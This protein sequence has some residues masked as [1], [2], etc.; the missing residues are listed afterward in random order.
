MEQGL[1]LLLQLVLEF[2]PV[3]VSLIQKRTE[4][5]LATTNYQFPKAIKEFAQSVNI[6]TNINNYLSGGFEQEKLLQKQLA[7]YHRE[8]QLQIVNQKRDTAL[9]LPEVHKILD[10]WP[11]RLYPSQILDS[12]SSDRTPLKIFLAPPQVHFDQFACRTEGASEIELILAEGIREFINKYYSLQ[13][14]SRPTELLAGA[15][16]S[17]RF[18]SE[19]S[20]KALFG[21]LKTEPV[22]I[23]E[24]ENDGDYFNFRIAYWG[25]G[26]DKYYYQTIA[27]LPY[28]EI[29]QESAK[30]RALEWKKIRDELLALGENLEEI[31][32]L[33]RDNVYNLAILEKLEKWQHQGIDVSKLSL[34]Y[35]VDRQ[36]FEKLC[37]VLIACHCLVAAWVADTYHLVHYD[38]PPLLPKLLPSMLKNAL[39]LQS[40][41]AIVTGYKQVYQALENERRYW[42]PELALQLA[43]SLSNLADRAWANEQIEYSLS[44]WL[45]LRQ[46]S[47]QEFANPLEAM[48]SAIK[49]EDE[50]YI[51]KLKEYFLIVGDRQ[52]ILNVEKLLDAIAILKYK[53]TLES[54][55]VS[56]TITGHLDAVVSVAIS[57]DSEI[58]VSGC[59]DKTINVWN[60]NTGKLIRTLT[61]NVGEVSSVAVSPDGNFLVVGSCEHPKSNVQV[62]HLKTGKLLHTLLGHQKP[63]NV[64]AISPDGQILASG[65]NKI[66][67]WHLYKGDRICTL[68]H[69]SAVH[70]V[71]INPDAT[72]LASGSSDTKIRLWNP[73]SGD[74]LRTLNGHD[75]EIKSIAISPDG[76]LLFSGSADTTIKI[77]HLIT[78]KLLYTLTG[79]VNEVKSLAVSP[80]GQTL[81]SGSADKTIKIW[82]LSTGELLQTLTGHSQ[83]VNSVALSPNGKFLASGSS[84][85]TIR[86]WQISH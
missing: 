56:Y 66:K 80:N 50:E 65:S 82:Q 48:Q 51:Q 55:D 8:T 26:Q 63:V 14:P 43:Q 6:S 34:Q 76:Q 61:G 20:I 72:I 44:T 70:A 49:I 73:R 84:D 67:I 33:G 47:A 58:L 35:Q 68:W 78:G 27:R 59:A 11:L 60:I 3:I 64:V 86:M 5:S 77:W 30:T 10:S 7:I 21:A 75:G 74:P 45:E 13:S 79:H 9:K 2:T 25:L 81:I 12:A 42:I 85:K 4:E 53:R 69:S 16:D 38:V 54:P 18:H 71:A 23:L 39:D 41:Q 22:L 40:V 17:K 29:I 36:D 83:T 19:S 46:I 28:K 15:W 62:W 24:S 52:N 57:P 31:N 37:Q 32:L 1:R